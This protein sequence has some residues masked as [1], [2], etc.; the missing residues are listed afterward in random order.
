MPGALFDRL[1]A[2]R[3]G[4]ARAHGVPAYV[5][6]HDATLREIA[7]RE[8]RTLD[9]LAQ[10]SGVGARKLESYGA[11]ILELTQDAAAPTS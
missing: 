2:W 3:A 8:P 1:R 11:V 6:F 4:T 9:D 10:I 7:Q 5:I